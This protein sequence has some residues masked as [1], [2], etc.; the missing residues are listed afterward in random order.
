LFTQAEV[1]TLFGLSNERYI[2]EGVHHAFKFCLLV[3]KKGGQTE[4]FT[5][6]FR[7][8]PREAIAPDQLESFLHNRNEHVE[9][10]VPLVRRLS[11]D[12]LSVMEFKS[13]L[14]AQIAEKTLRFPYLGEQIDAVWN[15]KLAR[16]FDMTNDSDLFRTEY[17]MGCLP[18]YEGKMV[19][20][21][22]H[23]LAEPRYW[24]RENEGRSRLLGRRTEARQML[25]YQYYRFAYRSITGSTNRRTMVCSILPRNVFCGHS[26]NVMKREDNI[27]SEAEQIFFTAMMSSLV[28]DFSLRQ[29]VASQLTMFFVYHR[30]YAVEVCVYSGCAR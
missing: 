12:S 9:I 4:S 21:F 25:N 27:M 18:L 6:A 11:P 3:F 24:I 23:N 29:R 28:V 13:E 17:G 15:L 26:L 8:N 14:D 16:E 19:G 1:N 5:A 30:S 22:V 7:I 2:F 10:S 20:H